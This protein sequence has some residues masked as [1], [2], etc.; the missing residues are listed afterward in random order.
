LHY[1]KSFKIVHKFE[2]RISRTKTKEPVNFLLCLRTR[3]LALW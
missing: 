3:H 2:S 1:F